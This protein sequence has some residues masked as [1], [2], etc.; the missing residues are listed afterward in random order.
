MIAL[1][2]ATPEPASAAPTVWPPH[3]EYRALDEREEYLKAELER[4]RAEKRQIA[5]KLFSQHT[6]EP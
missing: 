5:V 1:A 4:V 6:H 3:P 2:T